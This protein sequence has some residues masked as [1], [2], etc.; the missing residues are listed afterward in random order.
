MM[1]LNFRQHSAE[2]CK[3]E[4]NS[5]LPYLTCGHLEQCGFRVALTA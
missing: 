1:R 4:T 3:S 5:L 2:Y